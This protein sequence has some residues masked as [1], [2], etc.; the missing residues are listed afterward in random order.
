MSIFEPIRCKVDPQD[1]IAVDPTFDG[2]I[3]ID[4]TYSAR[5]PRC[6]ALTPKKAK[7]LIKQIKKG[8]KQ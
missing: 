1:S 2:G 3:F 7:K 6:I 5:D 4:V 8:L